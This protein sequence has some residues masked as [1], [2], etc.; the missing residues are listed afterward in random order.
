M[1][2]KNIF[3]FAQCSFLLLSQPLSLQLRSSFGLNETAKGRTNL[4]LRETLAAGYT[5]RRGSAGGR[6]S[7][8]PTGVRRRHNDVGYASSNSSGTAQSHEDRL[9]PLSPSPTPSPVSM[10]S[11]N[12]VAVASPQAHSQSASQRYSFHGDLSESGDQSE[13]II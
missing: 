6:T 2:H 3:F 1:D 10:L 11:P 7:P 8:F 4:E 5:T 13:G 12:T 9:H